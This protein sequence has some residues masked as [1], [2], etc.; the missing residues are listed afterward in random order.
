MICEGLLQYRIRL[1]LKTVFGDNV[2]LLDWDT[3]NTGSGR[4]D[5]VLLDANKQLVVVEIECEL[6]PDNIEHALITQALK[7]GEEWYER[8]NQRDMITWHE[9]TSQYRFPHKDNP[10]S[11]YAELDL[12]PGDPVLWDRRKRCIIIAAAPLVRPGVLE[13]AQRAVES[14]VCRTGSQM[15]YEARIYKV[16][17]H[18]NDED[19]KVTG[20]ERHVVSRSSKIEMAPPE[21]P[22][23]P[24]PHQH[25]RG[26]LAPEFKEV[27]KLLPRY[28]SAEL[29]NEAGYY[30]YC[31]ADFP[32]VLKLKPWHEYDADVCFEFSRVD[33]PD[34]PIKGPHCQL[35]IAKLSNVGTGLGRTVQRLL[36]L[37]LDEI[38][39]KLGCPLSDLA[40]RQPGWPLKQYQ[41]WK[42][43]P[44]MHMSPEDIARALGKFASV[45]YPIVNPIIRSTLG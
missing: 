28:A 9:Y 16:L 37:Q 29:E 36:A 23:R 26:V 8:A 22:G 21:G 2:A 14:Y 25:R 20:C 13:E 1:Q 5:V 18:L 24:V 45:V 6:R 38:A 17:G 41:V 40:C 11:L 34:N 7:G 35:R 19:M 31:K 32:K 30:L 10:P 4:P 15:P 27:R 44:T 3:C 39:D 42:P 12:E 33:H 43:N